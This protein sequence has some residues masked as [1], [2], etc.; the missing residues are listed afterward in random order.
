MFSFPAKFNRLRKVNSLFAEKNIIGNFSNMKS[1]FFWQSISPVLEPGADCQPDVHLSPLPSEFKFDGRTYPLARHLQDFKTTSLLVMHNNLIVHESYHLG[2]EANDMRISWS[3]AKSFL[4]AMIGIGVAEGKIIS[5]EDAVT[6]YVPALKD[7][8]Y[9]GIKIRD[10]LNMSSGV[11]F[12]ED[13]LNYFSDIKRMGRVLA[14]GKSMDGFAASFKKYD[15]EAGVARQY[16]SI[17]THVLAMVLRAA[18]GKSLREYFSEKIWS[19]IGSGNDLYY[20]TDGYGVD[21][22]LGGLN[23]RSRDFLRFGQLYLNDGNWCGKQIVPKSWIEQSTC[24]SAPAPADEDDPMQYGFQWWIPP[25]A[26]KEYYA[27]GVYGQ[28]IYINPKAKIVIVKTAA[29]R[30]FREPGI[31]GYSKPLE[32]IAMFRSISEHYSN[33]CHPFGSTQTT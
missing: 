24:P 18:T 28:Y 15:R 4:S 26:D 17:D 7:S 32:N 5:I 12:N 1:M 13:Y 21:F 29:H 8:A 23:M 9:N 14:L 6:H 3:I 10:V 16:I 19:K 22:A 11:K 31:N 2:T 20:L 25:Q 30:E 27:V 33:W